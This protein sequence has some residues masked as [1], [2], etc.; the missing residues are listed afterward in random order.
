MIVVVV[1]VSVA[2]VSVVVA[3]V[4]AAIAVAVVVEWSA[5]VTEELSKLAVSAFSNGDFLP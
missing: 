2:V 5:V 4:V 3:A 1:V